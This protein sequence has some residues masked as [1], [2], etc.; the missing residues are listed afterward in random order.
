MI[1]FFTT[2]IEH[3][4][5]VLKFIYFHLQKKKDLY[6]FMCACIIR[7]K[8]YKIIKKNNKILA[9]TKSFYLLTTPLLKRL[10]F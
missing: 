2:L 5:I 3:Q 9:T 8:I 10:P 6:P 4:K 1:L 7:L